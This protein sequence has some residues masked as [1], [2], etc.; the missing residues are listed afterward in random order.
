MFFNKKILS[1]VFLQN[2]IYAN[3]IIEFV[4]NLI[5]MKKNYLEVGFTQ[6]RHTE[7]NSKSVPNIFGFLKN[8]FLYLITILKCIILRIVK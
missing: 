8:G 6:K 7:T 4:F 5:V 3:F 1:D 2:S